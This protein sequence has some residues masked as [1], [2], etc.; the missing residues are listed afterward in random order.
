MA[1]VL[2]NLLLDRKSKWALGIDNALPTLT[3]RLFVNNI[4]PQCDDILS[5]YTECTAPGYAAET[6][7][8]GDWT[9]STSSCVVTYNYPTIT[10][11]FTGPGVPG[12]TIYGHLVE[13]SDTG[14]LWWAGLWTTPYTIP[15]LGGAAELTIVWSDK[16]CT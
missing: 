6:L 14:D 4:T 16:Q 1:D 2:N 3:V 13:D 8:P 12:Q 10:F 11:T 15:P 5:D 7:T 9:G